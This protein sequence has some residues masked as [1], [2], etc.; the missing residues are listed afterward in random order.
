VCSGWYHGRCLPRRLLEPPGV[1]AAGALS[2]KIVLIDFHTHST[3]S[4]GA[5]S[6]DELLC[7][8]RDGGVGLLAITDHDSVAGYLRAQESRQRLAP[9]VCLLPGVELSCRWSGVAVH[10]VGLGMDCGHPAMCEGLAAL[11]AARRQRGEAIA[12]GLEALGFG[13]A[14]DGA[15]AEAGES[16]LARPHFSTW[17]VQQGYARDHNQA[18]DKYLGQGRVGDV[19]AFWP[20]LAEVTGWIAE[21]GGVAVLAHPLKYRLTGMKLK[22]L[23]TDFKA[24]GG[25]AIEIVSG[26]QT[27]DQVA[28]LRRLA[29]ELELEVSVGSD[30]HRD[31]PYGPQL[32]VELPLLED[33]RGVWKRW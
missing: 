18:F 30:F 19:K 14:L 20:E 11:D 33:L 8:A 16:Q 10:V 23:A 4:D 2:V 13:G 17:L 3:A 5:L 22:R 6:P 24:A 12:H 1:T 7:R 9:G 15:L 26:R 32:G 25:A 29:R 28:R 31:A 21:A 27:A